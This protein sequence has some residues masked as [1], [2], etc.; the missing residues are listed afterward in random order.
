MANV[1][2]PDSSK[3]TGRRS[4]ALEAISDNRFDVAVIGGGIN[5]AAIALEC[6][7]RG[8]KVVLLEKGDI[9]SGTSSR[10]SRLVH[11]GVRYLEYGQIGL[12]FQASRE[13]SALC[14]IAP[15]LVRPLAF[16]WPI[17]KSSRIGRAKLRAGLTLYDILS[18]FRNFRRHRRLSRGDVLKSEPALRD[19]QL[20]GGALYYDAA[21]DDARLTLANARAAIEQGA[22]VLTYAKVISLLHMDEGSTV[23]F[24]D[25]LSG[26]QY[27][28]NAG[29]LV[30]ATGPWSG[31]VQRMAGNQRAAGVRGSR[32]SHIAVP[33]NRIGNR[34]AITLLSP[35]DG[36]VFFVLPAGALAIIGTTEIDGDSTADEVRASQEEV[37]YLLESANHYFPGAQLAPEDVISAWAGIRPLAASFYSGSSARSSREHDLRWTNE[38]ML[39]VSGGKLTTYR[40]VARDVASR[41]LSK[42]GQPGGARLELEQLPGGNMQSLDAERDAATLAA[43]DR[44]TGVHLAECYGSEWRNVWELALAD[45]AM[46]KRIHPAQIYIRAEVQYAVRAELA[47]LPAD[48]LVRRTKLAFNTADHGESTI[49]E[50]CAIMAA[51]LGW[52]GVERTHAARSCRQELARI[53][54]VR[55]H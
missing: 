31:E 22:S 20:L 41:L 53:F 12:V 35:V 32:G 34:Y 27:S 30:N 29:L 4:A 18:L 1:K 13:R 54:G 52:S 48:V 2:R 28:L 44:E 10:S 14:E 23:G 36:R 17:Y 46:Q 24:V 16:T 33:R 8:L 47:L 38:V 51:E 19:A 49:D 43:G 25:E 11:G 6:A 40:V 15:H 5:G 39:N 45:P 42:L 7:R 26:S 50:V 3:G 37:S 9:A 55:H 21:T